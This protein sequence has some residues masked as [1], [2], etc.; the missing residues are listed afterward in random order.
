MGA[1]DAGFLR[2]IQE[3]PPTLEVIGVLAHIMGGN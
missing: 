3:D 1:E 2:N